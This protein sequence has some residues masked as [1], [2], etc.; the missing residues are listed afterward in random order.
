MILEQ[1]SKSVT[2]EVM[3]FIAYGAITISNGGM[4]L[5]WNR[6]PPGRRTGNVK[7]PRNALIPH[8]SITNLSRVIKRIVVPS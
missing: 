6:N 3:P 8:S 1:V 2:F 7:E 5:L 4:N